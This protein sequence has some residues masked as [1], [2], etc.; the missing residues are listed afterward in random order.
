M[1]KYFLR[2]SFG[3]IYR[4][5]KKSA[6]LTLI[7]IAIFYISIALVVLYFIYP[8]IYLLKNEILITLTFFAIWR[9]G[10]ML[11]NYTRSGIYSFYVY[12][13]L[14]RKIE[15]IPYEFR[16][17]KHLYFMIPSYKEEFWVSIETF[18][19]ILNEIEK[20]PSDV[21]IVVAT[22]QAKED[23]VIS[24]MFKAYRGKKKIDLI[25]Q[26]QNLGKRIAMGHALRAISRKYH[27]L[28]LNDS[29]SVTIFMDGDSYME[30]GFLLKLLPFFAIDKNLGAVTTNEAA[31]ID[32]NSKWYKEWF[33]LKFG[34]RHIQF[35]SH[36][37]SS[38]VMTL[39]GRLSAYRSDIVV[40]E[41]FIKIVENDILIHPLYGKFRF[42]MGDDKSTWFYLL[43]NGYDMLYLPD[44]L[45]YSLESRDGNFLEL[46]RSLPF[47][48]NGN[49]LRN[50]SRALA[51]G[52]KKTG[53][54]I[55]FVILDQKINMWTS[56]VGITSAIILSV[57][58]S[59]YYLLF[60]IV[61]IIFVR[62]FQMSV[63]ASGG[64]LVS[65]YTLPIMIYTQWVGAIVKINAYHD[66]A[67]QKWSKN[68]VTQSADNDTDMIK[69]PLVKVIPKVVKYSSILG[70]I[71]ILAFSH[72]VFYIPK[73]SAFNVTQK[74]NQKYNENIKIVDL[75]SYGVGVKNSKDNAKIINQIIKKFQG[76]K[77]ILK[78]PLGNID[79][80]EP[81]IIDKDNIT[82]KGEGKDKTIIISH[83]K[84]PN[85]SAI[86]VK[87]ERGKKIGYLADG[88]VKGGSIFK[89]KFDK[90]KLQTSFLLLK[91]PNSKKFLDKL[92]AKK[93]NK[94]YPYLRQQIIEVA[95]VDLKEN[96][97]YTKKPISLNLS[98][99]TTGVYE[100][101]IVSG[102]H[103]EDF[104]IK[105]KVLNK[106][107][108]KY[109]SIYEN[110]FLDFQVDTVRF[111]YAANCKIVNIKI[112]NAGRHSL[113]FENSY[114]LLADRLVIDKSWNKGKGGSGYLRIARTYHSEV[115]NSDIYNIRHVVLQWSSARNHLHHLNMGVDI[116]FHGGFSHDN[117]I[118]NIVFNIPKEH[119]WSEIEHTPQD[120]KWAPPDGDNK[121]DKKTIIKGIR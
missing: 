117:K 83:L 24:E 69:H 103:L 21:T 51:L 93:W 18:R 7:P 113:V 5:G 20:I 84:K 70:F 107:I 96:L 38:K 14:K 95:R 74:Q 23:A 75:K 118:D 31:Y 61:W 57:F 81:I 72:G 44:V 66:L 15:K 116:N 78:L 65:I 3:L 112:L 85:L 90:K 32:T 104:Q 59:F 2:E 60:F 109:T 49:T 45:C 26:H 35:Q 89:V 36:S 97:I 100:L 10:W 13:K 120:A 82:L 87:G 12:P 11:L 77:L 8:H 27:K 43:K 9:Y 64:H 115:K 62:V 119:L 48:W 39:T 102:V 47:R 56:L 63:I 30:E 105:Q 73:L 108:E 52:M 71:F 28:G 1:L 88:I 80:Y 6:L 67:N 86:L 46:S 99:D 16:Y 54:F 76:K 37:L 40:R 114:N 111:D 53:F 4:Y 106:N 121:I 58:K 22:S 79:I 101:N 42:L 25:F 110:K 92:G 98:Q 19:S 91:E 55:W 41:D 34:Q 94:K 33:N 29:N 68:G 50:N 17:P